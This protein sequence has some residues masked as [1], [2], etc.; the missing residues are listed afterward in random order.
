MANHSYNQFHFL[1]N[2][3]LNEL[4]IT[5]AIRSFALSMIIIFIPIYLIELGFSLSSVFVFFAVWGLSHVVFI[6]PAAYYASRYG[7]K[8]SIFV[9]IPILIVFY[10]LLYSIERFHWPLMLVAA[11]WGLSNAFF[12]LG[13]HVDF[14]ISS[15]KKNRGKELGFAGVVIRISQVI[16]PLTGSDHCIPWL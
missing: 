4:Y 16:G 11:V 1:N 9:G 12:W 14:S 2:W 5:M 15:D 8:H 13:Y 7:F 10:L 6:I 3:K